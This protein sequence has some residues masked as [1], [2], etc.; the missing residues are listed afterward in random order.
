MVLALTLAGVAAR[1]RRVRRGSG[2]RSEA[3]RP[4]GATGGR[5]QTRRE[6]SPPLIGRPMRSSRSIETLLRTARRSLP[7]EEFDR[8]HEQD[9]RTRRRAA[10]AYP[11]DPRAARI[12]AQ[13][14]G[15]AE[16]HQQEGRG[17]RRDRLGA[18]D[19]DRPRAQEIALFLETCLTYL[20]PV[21]GLA[22]VAA[23][24]E[25]VR[26]AGPGRQPGR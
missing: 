10:T 25:D 18:S 4:G 15:V 19:D 11:D 16:L 17:P 22:A 21:S 20:E 26:L 24:A 5:R 9:R 6:T 8:T 2:A 7:Q 14:D 12:R 23:R 3:A 1:G 13:S